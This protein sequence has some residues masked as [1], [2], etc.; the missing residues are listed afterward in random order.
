[1]FPTASFSK[2][3]PMSV[4]DGLLQVGIADLMKMAA[5]LLRGQSFP[6]YLTMAL[7]C[8]PLMVSETGFYFM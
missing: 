2:N 8:V 4:C 3:A 6:A 5:G 7:I 1:M